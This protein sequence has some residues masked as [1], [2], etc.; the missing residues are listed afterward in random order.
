MSEMHKIRIFKLIDASDSG[1]GD[2]LGEAITDWEEISTEDLTFLR[3]NI[4]SVVD[5]S[6]F[7][8][9]EYVIVEQTPVGTARKYI[10]SLKAKIE[11]KRREKEQRDK[12]R[13]L[14][15]QQEAE[16]R[17][18]K[19]AERGRKKLEKL[20]QENPDL[21]KEIINKET[22]ILTTNEK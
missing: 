12:E 10:D 15:R 6:I 4:R 17:A 14:L 16:K 2:Q 8:W 22:E 5:T 11:E 1:Y 9:H 18:K 3:N 21:L 20:L 13:E 7:G 19:A